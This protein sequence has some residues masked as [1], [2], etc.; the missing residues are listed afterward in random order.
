MH[1]IIR[2]RTPRT[3]K[4]R[5]LIS[6]NINKDLGKIRFM[7]LVDNV[8]Q[9]RRRTSFSEEVD[10]TFGLITYGDFISELK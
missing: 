5:R 2:Y 1:K 4:F 9:E 7:K 6:D 10:E 8:I 3:C